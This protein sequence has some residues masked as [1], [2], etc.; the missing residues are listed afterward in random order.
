VRPPAQFIGDVEPTL[1]EKI[2][3]VSIAKKMRQ[4]ASICIAIWVNLIASAAVAD[5]LMNPVSRYFSDCRYPVR[6]LQQ[7][8]L[9]VAYLH[10]L[11]DG[12]DAMAPYLALRPF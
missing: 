1:G 10:G 7:K 12:L 2:L 4:I 6:D 5:D 3:E 8:T 11:I 9:C